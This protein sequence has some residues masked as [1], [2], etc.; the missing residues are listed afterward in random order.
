MAKETKVETPAV[1]A[2]AISKR[3]PDHSV[4][5]VH[6]EVEGLGWGWQCPVDGCPVFIPDPVV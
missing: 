4:R 5:L 3:C 6:M 1:V 2:K